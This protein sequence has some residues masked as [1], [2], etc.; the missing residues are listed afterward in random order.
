MQYCDILDVENITD[1]TAVDLLLQRYRH[2][3]ISAQVVAPLSRPLQQEV[4]SCDHCG[5][6]IQ[7]PASRI[8]FPSASNRIR[9]QNHADRCE[10][11]KG[12][13]P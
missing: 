3:I 11:K 4:K 1:A 5:L 10:Q 13:Q 6:V 9:M 2:K 7:R 8:D 12:K